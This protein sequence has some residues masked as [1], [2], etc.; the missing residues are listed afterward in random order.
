LT[1]PEARSH[2]RA[3]PRPTWLIIALIGAGIGFRLG[4]LLEAPPLGL[5]EARLAIN[6]GSRSYGGLLRPLEYDQSA[7]LLYL[8]AQRAVVDL[9]GMHDWVLRLLPLAFGVAFV[10]LVP[11]TFGRLLGARATAVATAVAA[12]SPLLIQ[13]SISV[14]QYGIEAALT[15]LVVG[16]ALRCREAGYE[17]P[18]AHRV[19]ALGTFLPWL[20]APAAFVLLAIAGSALADLRRGLAGAKLFLLRS[21]PAWAVSSAL[22]YL[23]VYAPASRS[24]YLRRYWS[25]A[26][27][28][29]GDGFTERFWAL[30]NE[31]LWGLAL[32]YPGP[33]GRHLPNVVF[34]IV[35]V[36]LFLVMAAGCR[37][38]LARFGG[39]IALLAAGPLL[40]AV[41]ASLVGV[42]PVGLRLT[43]FAISLV[44]LLLLSGLER[45]MAGLPE[46]RARRAWLV[47]GSALVVP[48]AAISLLLVQ[49]AG[50]SENVRALVEDLS[51]RRRHE[52]LY[53][54]A[55]SIPPWV[56]YSTDWTS[57]DRR[58]LEFASR[59]ATSGGAAFE[60]A[61]SRARVEPKEGDGLEYRAATGLE[62]YG[63][64]TGIEWTPNLGPR[65]YAPDDGWSETEALRLMS[66]DAVAAWVLMSHMTGSEVEL[67]R[68][69]ERRGMCATYVRELDNAVLI[70]YLR[71]AGKARA[72]CLS[73]LPKGSGTLIAR[74]GAAE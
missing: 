21:V 64:A 72:Q 31:N 54:F 58:R 34:L 13:Y 47:V 7:P 16:L 26:M 6:I 46:V 56:Y 42:Y 5:D 55:G 11:W 17:R 70:R 45:M 8:W 63:L 9:L 3:A 33:P 1:R 18:A 4:A 69:L 38:L 24:P 71:G 30:L 25:S 12:F 51:R 57:P 48:L 41:S 65:K 40:A 66:L 59:A 61:P 23:V 27:L 10:L 73:R 53:V 22:A 37:S 52:P 15:L 28:S 68:E 2:P 44:Q 49:R 67:S 74:T 43:L 20:M 62:L 19:T 39:S 36:A 50:Q 32:G 60:N 14:K 29:P 35:A